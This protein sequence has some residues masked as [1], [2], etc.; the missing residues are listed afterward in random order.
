VDLELARHLLRA[1]D[2]ASARYADPLDVAA[3][4]RRAHVSRT[5]FSRCFK[6]AYGASPHQYLIAR[7][8][9]RAALLL[10]ETDRSVT[11]ISLD[12]GFRSLGTFSTTFSRWLG[13]SPSAYRDG[14]EPSR[15]PSCMRMVVFEKRDER[16]RGVLLP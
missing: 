7:R 6:A 9:E 5:H 3:L 2:L 4:A 1:R 13:V 12:V 16:S 14:T 8:M 15:V 11:E 10:R